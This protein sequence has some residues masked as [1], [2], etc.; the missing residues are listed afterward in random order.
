[1]MGKKRLHFFLLAKIFAPQNS[2]FEN[3]YLCLCVYVLSSKTSEI[4]SGYFWHGELQNSVLEW[5][6]DSHKS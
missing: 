2:T 5:F 4:A 6:L 1:M 3:I